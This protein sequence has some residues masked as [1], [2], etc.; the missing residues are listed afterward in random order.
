MS[1]S[2]VSENP[3]S[4]SNE[5]KPYAIEKNASKESNNIKHEL[6]PYYISSPAFVNTG[7]S[8]TR[9]ELQPMLII[10]KKKED[11]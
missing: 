2:T 11:D 8:H 6:K 9:E 5:L 1:Q 3:T 4:N 7:T 10:E